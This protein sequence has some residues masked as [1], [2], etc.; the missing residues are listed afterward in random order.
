MLV[1]AAATSRSS[2][3]AEAAGKAAAPTVGTAE[4]EFTAVN[5]AAS[6]AIGRPVTSA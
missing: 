5:M 3:R 2:A 4:R 6:A 1:C